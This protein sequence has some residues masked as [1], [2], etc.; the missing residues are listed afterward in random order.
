MKD[1]AVSVGLREDKINYE[2]NAQ[3]VQY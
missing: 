3:Y 1:S 2:H